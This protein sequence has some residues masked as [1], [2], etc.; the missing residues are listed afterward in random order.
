[1]GRDFSFRATTN[2]GVPLRK[3]YDRCSIT[4]TNVQEGAGFKEELPLL[5]PEIP[6]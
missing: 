4:F 3:P 1:M 6:T 2:R 5:L